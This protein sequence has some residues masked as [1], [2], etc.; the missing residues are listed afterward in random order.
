MKSA[1][2]NESTQKVISNINDYDFEVNFSPLHADVSFVNASNE[3][4]LVAFKNW[5]EEYKDAEFIT[6][7]DGTFK[8][9]RD[10]EKMSKFRM[11]ALNRSPAPEHQRL[12]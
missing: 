5:R 6:E 4:D 8:V 2:I 12:G 3:L 10:V 1:K 7:Q 9:K 11:T